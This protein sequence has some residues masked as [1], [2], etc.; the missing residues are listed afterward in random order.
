MMPLL[1]ASQDAAPAA[2]V[3]DADA[4]GADAARDNTT[5]E[6]MDVDAAEASCSLNQ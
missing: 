5:E 2:A 3:A 4:L 1:P 6:A